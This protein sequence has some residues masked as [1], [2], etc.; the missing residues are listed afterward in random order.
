MV[1][2]GKDNPLAVG[3]IVYMPIEISGVSVEEMVDQS[4]IISRAMLHKIS[5]SMEKA[6]NHYQSWR[7]PLCVYLGWMEK[8]MVMN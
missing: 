4:T 2:T 5:R 8:E 7:F 1:A 6:G 3:P